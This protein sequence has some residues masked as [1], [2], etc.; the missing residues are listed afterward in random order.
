MSLKKI[1]SDTRKSTLHLNDINH[2]QAAMEHSIKEMDKKGS[3]FVRS[4]ARIMGMD[5]GFSEHETEGAKDRSLSKTE[6]EKGS[7]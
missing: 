1:Q 5:L 4:Q 7:E 3:N 6:L 2:N